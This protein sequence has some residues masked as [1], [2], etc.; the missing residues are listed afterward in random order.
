MAQSTVPCHCERSEAIQGECLPR[1]DCFT[2]GKLPRVRNE[3]RAP[4]RQS[5]LRAKRSNPEGNAKR[6]P[7]FPGWI[8]SPT[9]NCRGFAM[10]GGLKR[11]KSVKICVAI[12]GAIRGSLSLCY[13]R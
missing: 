9:A 13:L 5:S 3:G 10:T 2:H 1:L 12:Y 8:A 11:I 6:S 4:L 7:A